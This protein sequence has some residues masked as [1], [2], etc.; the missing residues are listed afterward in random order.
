M[1]LVLRGD[2]SNEVE[3]LV[4]R[5]QVAVLRRQ[6]HRLDL[7]PADR[8]VLSALSR[9][10]PRP[11][12]ATF[13]VT[14][15]TL[16]RWHRQLV[17]RKWTYPKRRP[18][19]PPVTAEVRDLVLRL[20]RQNPGWGCRRIQGELANLGYRVGAGTIRR[21]LTA[22]RIGPAPRGV[23][24]SWRRFLRAQAHGLLACDFF[25]VD[26]VALRR[27]YVLFV[28]EVLTRRVHPGCHGQPDRGVDHAAGP[29][30]GPRPGPAGWLVPVPDPGSGRQ[31]HRRLRR[32]AGGR[33]R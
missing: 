3:I 11:R 29:Q 7:E 27:I 16:L 21:I 25:H 4:L 2:R 14:P 12:W 6:V 19:R 13:F 10:L 28:M 1:R 15:A 9:L 17:A 18:G 30:P 33:G 22:A 26:T 24:T 32:G 23:D 5:H 20:A 31:V 8:A